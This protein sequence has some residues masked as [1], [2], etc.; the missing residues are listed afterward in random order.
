M[1]IP[2]LTLEELK[3]IAVV[4]NN[5]V[6]KLGDARVIIPIKDK[7]VEAIDKLDPPKVDPV[8]KAIKNINGKSV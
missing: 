7:L 5:G 2:N 6:Y 1:D 4:L 8:Q 3:V